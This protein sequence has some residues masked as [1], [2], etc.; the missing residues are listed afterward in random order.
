MTPTPVLTEVD[1]PVTVTPMSSEVKTPETAEREQQSKLAVARWIHSWAVA[2]AQ[3]CACI[4]E[5]WDDEN[6]AT[7]IGRMDSMALVLVDAANNV[8]RGARAALGKDHELV[9]V[10]DEAHPTLKDIRDS[11]E[12]F[13]E[14]VQG[15]GN[16]QKRAVGKKAKGELGLETAGLD[17]PHSFGGGGEGHV[18]TLTVIEPD[19]RGDIV[20]REYEIATGTL[21]LSVRA[22]TRDVALE[23][24]LFDEDHLLLCD[25]CRVPKGR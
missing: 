13:E 25:V 8:V 15:K 5:M 11:L 12:H 18:V 21:S 6:P 14:Y 4:D 1:T 3:T 24:G 20:E 23:V 19:E 7:S 16:R 10:F 22:L 2:A 17:L 9:K